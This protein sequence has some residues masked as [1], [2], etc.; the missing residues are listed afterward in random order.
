MFKQLW[1]TTKRLVWRMAAFTRFYW[2]AITQYQLHSPLAFDW[3]TAVLEDEERHFYAFRDVGVLREH[4]LSNHT[5]IQVTDYGAGPDAAFDQGNT[6]LPS[7]QRNTTIA[8]V[9][10]RSG[11]DDQ[12]GQRLFRL[13]NWHKPRYV[14]ELGTNLGLGTL[15]IAYALPEQRQFIT[16]EGCPQL[17][18]VA[19][20]HLETFKKSDIEVIEGPFQRS[21]PIALSKLPQLDLVYFDGDHRLEPTLH[22]FQQC[23]AKA[24]NHSIFV[25]DDVHWSPGMEQ[26]W[27]AIKSHPRVTMTIDCWDFGC[28]FFH[29]EVKQKQHLSFVPKWWK[30]WKI[31]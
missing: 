15:Y 17:A 24:Q 9:A 13:V 10:A 20:L 4:L 14:L 5:P 7:H 25:F 12:Q 30:P 29:T 6:T 11:S 31:Y 1:L 19:R 21:L 3:A 28:V 18:E 16:L 27:E 26:A 8:Q 2:S 22:Y 23:L